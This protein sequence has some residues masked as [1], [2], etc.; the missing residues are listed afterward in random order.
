LHAFF[1]RLLSQDLLSDLTC[2]AFV[3]FF[4]PTD[5]AIACDLFQTA[6]CELRWAHFN[7]AY[8]AA[9]V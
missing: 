6:F 9:A 2:L 4:L 7:L 8:K 5:S 1:S 3:D